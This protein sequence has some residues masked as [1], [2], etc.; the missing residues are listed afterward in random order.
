MRNL[1]SFVSCVI[2]A[3]LLCGCGSVKSPEAILPVP[4][5]RQIDWQKMEMYAFVHYGLN[6][7][8]D[9]EWGYGDVDPSAFNPR[10]MD[11]EQWVRTF[12]AAGMQGVILTAKHH[13]GFCLWPTTLTDYNISQSPY[14]N[15]HG[16]VVGELAA[17]CKK[18]GL[19][20]GIY[21]S[22]WDRNRSDYGQASYL[23]YYK[24]ELREL[25]SNYGSLFEVWFDGANGGDGYY[26]GANE[27]RTIDRRHY[28]D[29]PTLFNIVDSLQ[30]N[31]V[32]F[33]DGGPGCRWVGNENGHVDATNWSFL[34]S[35]EVY[36]GYDRP[37]T[38][39]TGHADGDAWMPAE[40]N[41][42]IRPGWFYHPEEDGKVKTPEQLL[43]L[44]YR[45]VGHGGTFLL[46]F[47]I[48]R[49]GLVHPVDSA[50]AVAFYQRVKHDLQHNL[51]SKA[52]A[53]AS[54][55]RGKAYRAQAVLDG[56]YDTYW[57]TPDGVDT[58]SLTITLPGVTAIDRLML[59]EY[60][61]LGQRV[62]LFTVEYGSGDE[63][64]KLDT[65]EAT[66]TI[67]YKRILRFGTIETDRLRIKI[68]KSRGPVCINNIEA[69][70]AE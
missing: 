2:M 58:A 4:E 9:H 65:G 12:K 17:A 44:Y 49:D 64:K 33:S 21:L 19:R 36:P 29:F 57:A 54:S 37:E 62:E 48:D 51:L 70:L 16:D 32:I 67:G 15:G 31:A 22:P 40:C 11:V 55:S 59:Q 24:A 41:V 56:N 68:E 13:D 25:L 5:Q 23:D 42:S 34:R 47:P 63:W 60:I 18:Y 35:A 52:S 6:T 8:T 61:P 30:P 14:K 27:T 66:T 3:A 46:N 20:F 38:L 53:E 10:C 43:D 26:G 39:Y 1:L 50:N 28:Y 45:S 69:F 7:F